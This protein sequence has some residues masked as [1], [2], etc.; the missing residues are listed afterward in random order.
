MPTPRVKYILSPS[1]IPTGHN[2]VLVR[3]GERYEKRDSRSAL[4]LLDKNQRPFSEFSF[5]TAVR[6]AEG[7]GKREGLSGIFACK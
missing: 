5:L 4:R 2:Y 6:T 7:I 1:E 3:Y